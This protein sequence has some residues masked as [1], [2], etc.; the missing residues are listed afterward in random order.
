MEAGTG[1]Q[2]QAGLFMSGYNPLSYINAGMTL[3]AS[4]AIKARLDSPVAK[5][6]LISPADG[7]FDGRAALTVGTQVL[8]GADTNVKFQILLTGAIT[9]LQETLVGAGQAT[10]TPSTVTGLGGSLSLQDTGGGANSGGM[11]MFGGTSGGNFAA[12]K[13]LLANGANNTTGDLAI[14]TRAATTDATL[15]QR[16][17]FTRTGTIVLSEGVNFVF[18]TATGT[19]IG[20]ATSQ[21]LGFYG[22]T[23]VI[24][25]AGTVDVVASLVTLGL[26]AATSNP[27]LNLGTGQVTSGAVVS[28][29]AV[30][31]SSPTAGAGYAT[32]AGGTVT[33]ATSRT[34]GV[35]L[36]KVCGQITTNTTSL[37]AGATARFTVTN[38]AVAATD[39][40]VVSIKSGTTTDQTD[41]KV[42][43]V[44]AGSFDLV[45]ANR[46]A[47]TAEVGAII[48]NYAVVKAVTA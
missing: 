9:G 19:Q 36:S 25:P 3:M 45:V 16:I 6:I 24:Q 31:S 22:A 48:I 20:T 2:A 14:S 34:T 15:T 26:R 12:I 17:S 28:S 23:A 27:P 30:T 21:K 18:G 38:T 47:T 11:L 46:H 41:V 5:G 43:A 40:V 44:A 13:G 1:D 33:Q 37:A 29:A 10:T 4:N 32:G 39:N 35:T 8:N 42:Q 7:T